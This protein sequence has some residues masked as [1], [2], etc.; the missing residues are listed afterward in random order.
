MNKYPIQTDKHYNLSK[1]SWF[2]PRHCNHFRKFFLLEGMT[3]Q[4]HAGPQFD[5]KR[6]KACSSHYELLN[7][8]VTPFILYVA[9]ISLINPSFDQNWSV[10]KAW[11]DIYSISLV[12]SVTKAWF[13]LQEKKRSR[14]VEWYL[15]NWGQNS[16]C[17]YMIALAKVFYKRRK[18]TSRSYNV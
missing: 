16:L 7:I 10:T 18:V 13:S 17:S 2:L 12:W 6:G 8:T 11:Y 9:Q 5:S 14:A 1:F 3:H 15:L 4:L